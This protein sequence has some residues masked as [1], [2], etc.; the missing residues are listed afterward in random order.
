M[1]YQR[2]VAPFNECIG[3]SKKTN[4]ETHLRFL[5][6]VRVLRL[7]SGTDLTLNLDRKR[8]A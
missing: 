1:T 3:T 8:S 6:A 2:R 5:T 7:E 4:A